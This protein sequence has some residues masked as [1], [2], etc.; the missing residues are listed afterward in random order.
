MTD[1]AYRI[2]AL[3][4]AEARAAHGAE[5]FVYEFAWPSPALD[6][7]L[8][9]CHMA[10]IGFVFGNLAHPLAGPDAPQELSDRV[11]EA[12]SSFA[13]TGRPTAARPP[14]GGLPHW[15]AYAGRRSVMRLDDGA[16]SIVLEDPAADRRRLWDTLREAVPGGA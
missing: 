1:Y 5:T 13:R 2:P 6:G 14:G 12:W 15:P 3:R 9:A 16:A 10:E 8:G 7:A 4:V 11:R